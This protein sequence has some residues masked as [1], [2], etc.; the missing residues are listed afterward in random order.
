MVIRPTFEQLVQDW[1]RERYRTAPVRF[2]VVD[3][4]G[5]CPQGY[6]RG[7]VVAV[8]PDGAV[9]GSLC[10][11]ARAVLRLAALDE[12]AEVEEWCCPIFDH[13]LVFRRV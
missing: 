13:M 10:A 1:E 11:P 8:D 12:E 5:D 2:E 3:S 6:A 7:D 9:E 4:H